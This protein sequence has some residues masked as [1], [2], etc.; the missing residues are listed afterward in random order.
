MSLAET[1]KEA[2]PLVRSGFLLRVSGKAVASCSV[3]RIYR[4]GPTTL[5]A[6]GLIL[7]E[8]GN[9]LRCDAPHRRE[10][11]GHRARIFVATCAALVARRHAGRAVRQGSRGTRD[12][13]RADP[14]G[15]LMHAPPSEPILPKGLM[16]SLTRTVATW[17]A[18]LFT[19][20]LF[21]TAATSFARVL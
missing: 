20:G 12:R 13:A 10:G 5:G 18:A 4:N 19:T 9:R 14:H 3:L 6:S 15:R 11:K 7:I 21:V 1:R 8:A 2:A 17:F 16:M